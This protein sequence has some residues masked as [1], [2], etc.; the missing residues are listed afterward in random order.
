MNFYRIKWYAS[1]QDTA[2]KQ[3]PHPVIEKIKEFLSI[4]F[5]RRQ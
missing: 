3:K 4:L 5:Y 2:R 1:I